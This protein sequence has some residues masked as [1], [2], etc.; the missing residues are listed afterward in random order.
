VLMC[1]S[2]PLHPFPKWRREK[3]AMFFRGDDFYS[4]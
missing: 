2:H 3:R 4:I 1:L